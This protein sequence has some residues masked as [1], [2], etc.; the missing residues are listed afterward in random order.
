MRGMI[1][2][3]QWSSMNVNQFV[4]LDSLVIGRTP[5]GDTKD[6]SIRSMRDI[7]EVKTCSHRALEHLRCGQRLV[8][9][10]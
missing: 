8:C 7:G 9:H 6:V 1:T 3:G 2:R 10:G 4:L 5:P